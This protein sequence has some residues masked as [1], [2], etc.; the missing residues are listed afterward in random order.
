MAGGT[1]NL[2]DRAKHAAANQLKGLKSADAFRSD[3]PLYVRESTDNLIPGVTLDDF[4][5]DLDA[6]DGNELR[7]GK[8]RPARF[9]ASYSSSALVINTFAPF[10]ANP[11]ALTLAGRSGFT[12]TLKFAGKCPNGLFEANGEPSRSPN[13]DVLAFAGNAVVAVESKFL[14]PFTKKKQEL[15]PRFLLPFL[16]S[17]GV[18]P[19]A[20]PEWSEMYTRVAR[21]AMYPKEDLPYTHLDAAQ[22]VT[23]YLGLKFSY[24]QHTRVLI[25]LYWE[26]T[27]AGGLDACRRHR[28]EVRDFSRR[29]EGCDTKFVA[30]SYPDLWHEWETTSTWPGMP[31]HLG[32]LRA[33]YRFP[34]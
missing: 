16:G 10:K 28:D 31:G 33:R 4:Q 15:S 1:I 20:E 23:H 14:E 27:N 17:D 7:D 30:M 29:V 21:M 5:S 34:I 11:D 12:T 24:P 3:R 32:H 18:D 13:L 9:C 19:V 8:A 22:L 25:Y 26:P 2:L 6:T